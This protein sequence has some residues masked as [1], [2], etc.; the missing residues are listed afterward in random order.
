MAK[1]NQNPENTDNA[2]EEAN[3]K[4]TLEG[5]YEEYAAR[6]ED[7]NIK[8]ATKA[9]KS[10]MFKQYAAAKSK[11]DQLAEAL[12]EAKSEATEAVSEIVRNCGR[13][14][15]EYKGQVL[16]PMS[17]GESVFFRTPGGQAEVID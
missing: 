2:S 8:A 12:A 11:V 9:Q 4:S 17:R 6:S 3:G 15:F 10:A 7:P 13:G 16:I 14:P 1:K 5:L